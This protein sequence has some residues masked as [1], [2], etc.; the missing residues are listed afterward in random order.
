MELR[1]ILLVLALVPSTARAGIDDEFAGDR[2]YA[3]GGAHRGVGTSNDTLVL[4]PAGMALVRRY[5]VE[6]Q[7]GYSPFDRL[8]HI[9][10]SVVDSKTSPVAGGLGFTHDRGD[11][12]EVDAG[13]TRFYLGAA[14]AISSGI[15]FGVT[16]RYVRGSYKNDGVA[17]NVSLY[18]VDVGLMALIAE[19]LALGATY[20]NVIRYSEK[21]DRA[22]LPSRLAFG[23]GYSPN[24]LTLAFDLDMDVGR[25]QRNLTYH[26][27][28]E[29][30]LQRTFPI[31][32]GYE[33]SPFVRKDG[34]AGQENLLSAGLGW[35][36][37]G[38]A[39]EIAYRRSLDRGRNWG[40]V[41]ALKFFM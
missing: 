27:G 7:Y 18:N 30:L 5:A 35:V 36:N 25:A 6:L 10:T 38:G 21:L 20:S 11:A 31:R 39:I 41:G 32:L 19:G 29:Y 4:N 8:S 3:M 13:L 2:S 37:Q 15:G 34:S 23:L 17:R 40:I 26:A 12:N 1:P 24:E 9:N 14:Y 22:L 16:S 28:A 33:R